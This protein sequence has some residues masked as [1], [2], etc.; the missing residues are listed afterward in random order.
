MDLDPY[1]ADL[2]GESQLNLNPAGGLD[3]SR[4]VKSIPTAATA[5]Y[6]NVVNPLYASVETSADEPKTA[7]ALQVVPVVKPPVELSAPDPTAL[8]PPVRPQPQ[9]Q[10]AQAAPQYPPG[11]AQGIGGSD[12]TMVPPYQPGADSQEIQKQML[13]GQAEKWE[14]YARN[15]INQL[16]SA[17][18]VEQ[19][20]N[21]AAEKRGKINDIEKEQQQQQ[22]VQA[23]ARNAGVA[24]GPKA[25]DAT[26]L[27]QLKR[28]YQ[29]GDPIAVS[30]AADVLTASGQG[31]WVEAMRSQAMTKMEDTMKSRH[32]I[33]EE[34]SA[35]TTDEAYN[36]KRKEIIASG[37]DPGYQIPKSLGEWEN[38]KNPQGRSSRDEA[39]RKSMVMF[40]RYRT[41][42]AQQTDYNPITDEKAAKVAADKASYSTGEPM[43]Q[44]QGVQHGGHL[45]TGGQAQTGSHNIMG[46]GSDWNNYDKAAQ[47]EVEKMITAA[48]PT[49][50]RTKMAQ[51]NQ[52]YEMATT[53]P[54]TGKR[55]IEGA[56]E[57]QINT[58]PFVQNGIAEGFAGRMR[59]G[60]GGANGQLM[61]LQLA[62][63]GPV[64]KGLDELITA[65]AGG[66]NVV[67]GE[68][69]PYLS[70]MTQ[71]QMRYVLDFLKTTGDKDVAGRLGAAAERAG[72]YGATAD[73]LPL[74]PDLQKLIQ[75]RIDIGREKEIQNMGL[76][77]RIIGEDYSIFL[78]KGN[79]ARLVPGAIRTP[80]PA[81][82]LPAL[83]P[84]LTAPPPA[85]T[86][87]AP[88]GG[89]SRPLPGAPQPQPQPG[90]GGNPFTG[91]SATPV[92]FAPAAPVAPAAG[93]ALR[94]LAA[95]PAA[96][97]VQALAPR[98]VQTAQA[99]LPPSWGVG[100]G[101]PA[102]VPPTVPTPQAPGGPGTSTP[103]P[104]VAGRGGGTFSQGV[105]SGGFPALVNDNAT[106]RTV[107]G[108]AGQTAQNVTN[109]PVIANNSAIVAT[110]SAQSESDFN[111][112]TK[113]DGG[114]G[115]GLFGH[116][117]DRLTAMH[118][119]A[120]TKPGQP[121]PPNVQAAFYTREMS[122]AGDTDPFI[123]Q[124]MRNPNASAEDLT[125][126]QM[127]MERPQGYRGPGT[128]EQ[129]HNWTG[130]LANTKA[131]M[132]GAAQPAAVAQPAN[133]PY[134]NPRSREEALANYNAGQRQTPEEAAAYI[135]R[136]NELARQAT[137]SAAHL[138]P[139]IGGA[140]GG[141]IGSA[142]GPVGTVA[143]GALGGATGGAVE[144]YFTGT[145]EQQTPRGYTEAAGWG[146]L[147]G[148]ATNIGGIGVLGTGARIAGSTAIPVAKK[149]YEGGSAGEMYDAGLKGAA[150]GAFGEAFGRGLGMGHQIWNSLSTPGK[151]E[152]LAAAHV[153]ATQAPKIAGP[154]GKMVD[155]PLWK[156]AE[157]TANRLHQDPDTMA[158]NYNETKA[159]EAAGK[160]PRTMGE[161][162]TQRPGAVAE[163][164]IG[165]QQYD[166]VRE[167]INAAGPVPG[168]PFRAQF[169]NDPVAAVGKHPDIPNTPEY[170]KAAG[171][172]RDQMNQK[173][174]SWKEI[175]D[176]QIK[177][178]SNLLEKSRKA[179]DAHPYVDQTQ[180]I[181]AYRAM[182]DVARNQQQHI[183]EKLLPPD[184][185]QR[186]MKGLQ[187]AD[188]AYRQAKL[189]GGKDIVKKI[190]EG[191]DEGRAAQA[192]F[193]KLM[194][195]NP[196]PA[197]QGMLDALVKLHNKT[198][199][200]VT[201][202][203]VLG[204]AAALA[205]FIPGIGTLAG[206][207]ITATR[208]LHLLQQHMLQRAAGK[209]ATFDQLIKRQLSNRTRANYVRASSSLAGPAVTQ[210]VNAYQGAEAPQ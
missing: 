193:T 89:G 206:V 29:S 25:T 115:Y 155:N 143:G 154:G 169:A 200:Q 167:Q 18:E 208:G 69:S 73:K 8:T 161:V 140:A 171:I 21:Y 127:R 87:S 163:A 71:A 97:L 187:E 194:G 105:P 88:G 33:L 183:A 152:L 182:A 170:L 185:A 201:T 189:A 99:T 122:R 186:V 156:Q 199:Q 92:P 53:D 13:Q 102:P 98:P 96:S 43:H 120:G 139:A 78:G 207:G 67:T 22:D 123:A 129:A 47:E 175:W 142:G 128:E 124:T 146:G 35:A 54:K 45:A 66:K 165:R 195:K 101:G 179:E 64:Q 191:G 56:N 86:S 116:N 27:E 196:D 160:I 57:K 58:N 14:A 110:S 150:E 107:Y 26:V 90:G 17:K 75:G 144:N 198:V 119:F 38:P 188:D 82:S 209:T 210:G 85:A 30:N 111:P 48:N 149:W 135:A 3:P 145:P 63:L 141:V 94:P 109:N 84:E 65:Y 32:G 55:M 11:A 72:M 95:T 157:A 114:I 151:S 59:L 168:V 5:V 178:R 12:R 20:L 16:I 125:R 4:Q 180:D 192:A 77:N 176:N 121:I 108:T 158:Y 130:R 112:N 202:G 81:T 131:L 174:G 136:K 106:A 61:K 2:T 132:A 79:A 74:E 41:T 113:H 49:A 138:A 172:A 52:I 19:A 177:A 205:H 42:Q 24:V 28:K 7:K 117:A 126:V 10:I 103:P 181:K 46:Y 70:K 60:D 148:A 173:A 118:A 76:Q 91:G 197:A 50:E 39:F 15:P 44:V 62:K 104:P 1:G 34:L 6:P 166:P 31:A 147:R 203:G 80:V 23:K 9:V 190:A 100:A 162:L 37:R 40:Q 51:F 153:L 83:Y 68:M 204:G 184:Q 137:V 133:L 159:A 164:K 36:R 93:G 134:P